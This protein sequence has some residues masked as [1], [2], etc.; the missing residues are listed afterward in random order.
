MPVLIAPDASAKGCA[1]SIWSVPPSA[2]LVHTL[3][4][5]FLCR[6]THARK[7]IARLEPGGLKFG[8]SEVANAIA[9]LSI[10]DADIAADLASSDAAVSDVARKK[11]DARVSHRDG[12]LFQHVSW[13]AGMLQHPAA[14][15]KA[16]HLRVADK[17]FD[18]LLLEVSNGMFT[19]LVL[20]EDKATTSPRSTITQKVWPELEHTE[21]GG[22]D[23]ELVDAVTALLDTMMSEDDRVAVIDGAIWGRLRQ[24]RVAVTASP[25]DARQGGFG[26]L[27]L[28]FDA[29]APQAS[30][31]RNGEV[32]VL[33]DVRAWLETL[34]IQVIA[35][36]N[37]VAA[38][39]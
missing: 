25:Q 35:R 27:F 7:I 36:L 39:V 21:A 8:G 3:A 1:V 4:A 12:L 31:V 33:E 23:L 24:Y 16:P 2:A 14:K 34:A 29:K 15:A 13:I 32:L 9:L 10:D 26:R 5:S 30:T 19:K 18:G 37:E 28:G 17:G 20:C 22:K 11:W 38:G 6:P